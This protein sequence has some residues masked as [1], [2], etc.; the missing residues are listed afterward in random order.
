V[1]LG[2]VGGRKFAPRVVRYQTNS[3]FPRVCVVE[4]SG[5]ERIYVF[6]KKE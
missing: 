1:R 4:I 6:Y 3:V 2:G 5:K